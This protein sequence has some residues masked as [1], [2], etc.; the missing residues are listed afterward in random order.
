MIKTHLI[1]ARIK[2]IQ[3][4]AIEWIP[5]DHCPSQFSMM[6]IMLNVIMKKNFNLG[7]KLVFELLKYVDGGNDPV[8]DAFGE[9]ILK[10][11]RKAIDD[12]AQQA[13]DVRE[14]MS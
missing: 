14:R 12:C 7:L 8:A 3:T 6:K 9:H 4:E 5:D 1:L 10:I 11:G 13:I 2:E